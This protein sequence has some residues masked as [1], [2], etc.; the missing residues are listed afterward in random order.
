[1][2]FW[3][4]AIRD[5]VA[6]FPFFHFAFSLELEAAIRKRQQTKPV[7]TDYRLPR[8]RLK[9]NKQNGTRML[10][11]VVLRPDHT[12]DFSDSSARQKATR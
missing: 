4:Q 12:Q 3:G 9:S 7:A 10:T 5:W 1:M 6:W 2:L 11:L 8:I